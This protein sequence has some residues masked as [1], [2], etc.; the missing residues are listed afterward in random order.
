MTAQTA[1]RYALVVSGC[2]LV[3]C[4]FFQTGMSESFAYTTDVQTRPVLGFV[5]LMTAMFVVNFVGLFAGLKSH[6]TTWSMRFAMAVAVLCRLALLPSEAIQEVDLYRYLWDGQVSAQGVSPFAYPPQQVRELAEKRAQQRGAATDPVNDIRVDPPPQRNQPP[7]LVRLAD[8]VNDVPAVKTLLQR[9]HYAE[10]TT[11]YPPVSQWVFWGVAKLLPISADVWTHVLG[12]KFAIMLFDLATIPLILVLLRVTGR[13]PAWVIAYAW[14]PLV[15]K[16][17]SGSGHLDSIAVFFFVAAICL[18]VK[19]GWGRSAALLAIAT[20]AKL[21]PVLLLPA[22]IVACWQSRGSKTVVVSAVVFCC[23]LGMCFAPG[24]IAARQQTVHAVATAR[25]ASAPREVSG[26]SGGKQPRATSYTDDAPPELFLAENEHLSDGLEEAEMVQKSGSDDGFHQ[27]F[28]RWEM[29]DIAFLLI[30]ENLRHNSGA[31]H[32]ML[33]P[34]SSAGERIDLLLGPSPKAPF[35]AARVITIAIWCLVAAFVVARIK[36]DNPDS[37]LRACF[38]LTTAF[39]FLAPTLNPWYW[40]WA[41]PLVPF[42]RHRSWLLVAC[43]LSLYYTRFWC[44][45]HP[46]NRLAD[47]TGLGG[48]SLFDFGIVFVEHGVWITFLAGE[49][50]F[51]RFGQKTR[52]NSDQS[53]SRSTVGHSLR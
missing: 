1:S 52:A 26:D 24:M 13:S 14:N 41:L 42:A 4:C 38:A 15:L 12:M 16:E 20:A 3:V 48:A 21:F 31:P 25:Q 6:F 28:T 47:L 7:D 9:V 34:A 46:D 40:T 18:A 44:I 32:W 51:H 37:L 22:L 50:V 19:Q 36:R 53:P 33:L 29:N 8:H 2:L 27:F 43:C 35:V 45:Y 49:V 23:V 11:V 5:A 10:L 17:F 30:H 39:W